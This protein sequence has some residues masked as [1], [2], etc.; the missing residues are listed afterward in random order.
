MVVVKLVLLHLV[1]DLVVQEEVETH[2]IACRQE[3]HGT[4]SPLG[5]EY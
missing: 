5:M 4:N 2:Q 1:I 3:L